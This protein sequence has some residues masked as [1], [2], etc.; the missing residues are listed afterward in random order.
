MKSFLVAACVVL[1]LGKTA[2]GQTRPNAEQI[3]AELQTIAGRVAE[4]ADR[5]RMRSLL[6]RRLREQIEA[7]NRDSSA[8]WAKITTRAEWETFRR[9]KIEALRKSL[10]EWPTRKLPPRSLVTGRIPGEG[11]EIRNVV[12]ESRP[13]LVVT[14]NLYV[15]HLPRPSMPG[16]VLSHSHHN[17]K[18]QGELQDMGMTWARAGCYVLVPDHLGH[19]ERRQHPFVTA[20]DHP[21]TFQV[22][23]QDY[24]FRYDT[25]L[26]LYLAGESLMGWMVHDLMTGID[27]LLAQPGID[28]QKIALLGSVAGGGDPAAVTAAL[29]ERI[30][31]ICPFNF[32]GPQPETRYPLPDDAET[33]FNYAGGGSWESTRNLFRSAGDGFLPWVIVSSLAPRHLIHAHEFAWDGERDPVWK[34]YQKIWR[35][36]DSADHLAVAHGH[37]MLTSENPPGSHCN[38]IGAVHRR[39]IHEALRRWLGIEVQPADEFSARRS[40]RELAC[41]TDEARAEFQPRLLHQLLADSTSAKLAAARQHRSQLTP[42][43]QQQQIRECIVQLLKIPAASKHSAPIVES[44]QDE[45]REGLTIRTQMLENEPGNLVPVVRL[46]LGSDSPASQSPKKMLLAVADDGVVGLLRRRGDSIARRV[47]AGNEVVLTEVRGT[48]LSAPGDD[49]GPQSALTRHSATSLMLGEP[50]LAGQLRDLQSI[51]QHLKSNQPGASFELAVLGDSSAKARPPGEPFSYP[52]RIN[53][54]RPESRP[55]GALLALL[56]ACLEDDVTSVE[57]KGCLASFQSTLESPFVQVPHACILPGMLDKL[58]VHDLVAALAPRRVT[59]TNLVDG[60]GR[61]VEPSE[62]RAALESAIPAYTAA[63]MAQHLKIQ[64]IADNQ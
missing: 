48:G 16:I 2:D 1:A 27:L 22:G 59:L 41:L 32:G 15:P 49:Q 61:L 12:Y 45:P 58:D 55:A 44:S 29:D 42:Q 23:R 13:G 35:L 56:F 47:L 39:Q 51:W 40:A 34:R 46:T 43:Q 36:Y 52:H 38:N 18:E 24:Y 28:P 53:S 5:E 25:S 6:S 54:P 50:L 57:T 62:A 64:T 3:A 37:G 7:A 14:A 17:P 60:R 11:F 20:A 26:Q 63:S 10:G 19:G 31:C 30:T 4:S 9:E 21:A 33:S 8:A